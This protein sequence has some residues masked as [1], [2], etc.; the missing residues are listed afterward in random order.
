[1]KSFIRYL[2]IIL[3]VFLQSL[4]VV[5]GKFASMQMNS[6]SIINVILN[7]YYWG[8][9]IC[10]GLQAIFWQLALKHFKLSFAYVFN[11]LLFVL[12]LLYS[13]FIF[14]EKISLYNIIGALLIVGGTTFII[15]YRNTNE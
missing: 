10:L 11:S 14:K 7:P 13:F 3:S 4:T 9:L 12:I 1:M 15:T 6:F 8:V 5:L 2:Y